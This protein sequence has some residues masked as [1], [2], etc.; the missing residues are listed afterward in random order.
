MCGFYSVTFTPSRKFEALGAAFDAVKTDALNATIP[1]RPMQHDSDFSPEIA[2]LLR[3][4][5]KGNDAFM[6]GDMKAWL[7]QTPHAPDFSLV[8]PFGGWTTGGFDAAPERLAAMSAY[9]TSASTDLEVI[10]T[11]ASAEMIV[12]VV[13]ERQ[14]AVVG[15]LPEQDWSLRVTLVFRRVGT[16]WQLIHRHA[17]PLVG[18]IT[19]DQLSLIARGEVPGG[20]IASHAL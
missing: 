7:A 20:A 9:F 8:S 18:R 16:A 15:G 3:Q 17:D 11:H 10:A 4:V 13:V 19:L 2:T 14:R 5:A 12:L 1:D 6:N